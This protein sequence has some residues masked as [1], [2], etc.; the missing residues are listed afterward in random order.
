M[1]ITNTVISEKEAQHLSYIVT[2]PKYIVIFI[3]ETDLPN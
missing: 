1:S 3:H 2:K